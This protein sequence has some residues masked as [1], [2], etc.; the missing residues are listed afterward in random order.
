MATKGLGVM[1]G[2]SFIDNY[3]IIIRI[4][5]GMYQ[6][7]LP[8]RNNSTYD[9]H[10]ATLD[11]Q[12]DLWISKSLAATANYSVDQEAGKT[13]LES[14][15]TLKCRGV[16]IVAGALQTYGGGAPTISKD[17][18]FTTTL[19]TVTGGTITISADSGED[20]G[21]L[22]VNGD[23]S[24][25]GGTFEAWIDGDTANTQPQMF[26]E[27][28]LTVSSG[29]HLHINVVGDLTS[30]MDWRPIRATLYITGTLTFDS[31]TLFDIFYTIANV[32]GN[33]VIAIDV[34]SK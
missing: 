26:V 8:I 11:V 28:N 27:G 9:G 17:T 3:G 10:P 1:S 23:M 5:A 32:P 30:A 18:G 19:L 4:A 25:T 22:V 31:S 2:N 29:A 15:A 34:T 12:S 13:I 16:L 7:E 20:Y 6:I 24:W 14:S 33:P 21:A